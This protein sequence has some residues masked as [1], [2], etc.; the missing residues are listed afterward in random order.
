M[1]L[2]LV[3]TFVVK[4][5]VVIDHEEMKKKLLKLRKK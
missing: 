5:N 1:L 4:T 2:I 3:I